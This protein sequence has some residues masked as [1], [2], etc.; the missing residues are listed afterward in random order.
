MKES[1][2]EWFKATR[3]SYASAVRFAWIVV[4]LL[5]VA[6]LT[7]FS[8]YIRT[9]SELNAAQTNVA[10]IKTADEKFEHVAEAL[11]SLTNATTEEIND[12]VDGLMSELKDDFRALDMTIKGIRTNSASADRRTEGNSTVQGPVQDKVKEIKLPEE[13]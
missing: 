2:E 4:A 6:Y 7:T 11:Q 8:Q 5:L 3:D 9:Q 13:L 10:A 1:L 12:A